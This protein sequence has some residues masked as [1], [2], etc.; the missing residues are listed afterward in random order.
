MYAAEGLLVGPV[1]VAW[2]VTR[3]DPAANGP[4]RTEHT[5]LAG[6]IVD[7]KCY[8]GA[9][10][11][12]D[13]KGHKACAVLCIS[14]GIP[15]MLVSASGSESERTV[16]YYLLVGASGQ[17]MNARVLPFVAEAVEVS[18]VVEDWEGLRMLRVD[19]E[20]AALRRR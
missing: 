8:L 15:P 14:G 7:S 6:E 1:F 18:G 10:K 3:V 13:G 9:M 12:G 19:D 17:P 4:R 20:P 16:S 5:T 2:G 11:P